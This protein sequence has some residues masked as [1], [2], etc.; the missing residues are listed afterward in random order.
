M[1]GN[2]FALTS[3]EI[4]EKKITVKLIIYV[5]SYYGHKREFTPQSTV[6]LLT[7][8]QTQNTKH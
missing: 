1:G 3:F 4:F 5:H 7:L 8:H 6:I 2:V